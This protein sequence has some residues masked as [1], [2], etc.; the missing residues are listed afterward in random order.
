LQQ[1]AGRSLCFPDFHEQRDDVA[2]ILEGNGMSEKQLSKLN[3]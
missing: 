1:W 3:H 2:K